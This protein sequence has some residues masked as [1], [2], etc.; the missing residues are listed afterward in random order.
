MMIEGWV[1]NLSPTSRTAVVMIF[2]SASIVLSS[3]HIGEVSVDTINVKLFG[4]IARSSLC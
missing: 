2:L 4:D 3:F 1:L